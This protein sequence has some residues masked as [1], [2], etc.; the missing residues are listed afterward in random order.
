MKLPKLAFLSLFLP[1]SALVPGQDLACLSHTVSLQRMV[2]TFALRAILEED[3]DSM[4][5]FLLLNNDREG[6]DEQ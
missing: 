5:F 2:A 6:A 3:H 1:Q 4:S